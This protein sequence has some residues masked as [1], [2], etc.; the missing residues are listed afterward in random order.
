MN[1]PK[2][3]QH[4]LE[5]I[6][7]DVLKCYDEDMLVSC[8]FLDVYDVI[9]K[10][11]DVPYDWKYITPNQSVLGA[12]AF[13][14]GYIWVWP[15]SSYTKETKPYKI[16]VDAGTIIIDATLTEKDNRGRENFT[17]M[18]ELFHQ[19]LHKEVFSGKN[20]LHYSYTNEINGDGHKKLIT[21]MDFI[22][23]QANQCAA[24]FLM[25]RMVVIDVYNKMYSAETHRKRGILYYRD[26]MNRLAQEFNVSYT[27]ML[28]RVDFLKLK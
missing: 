19:I 18:H 15:E 22:E 28:N 25:P 24:C 27:A 16:A 23:Y 5:K 21:P 26:F 20:R 7:Y 4:E 14:D 6:A 17:V 12:T 8:K 11:L 1:Y 2:Y 9:E 3:N 13:S 10:I